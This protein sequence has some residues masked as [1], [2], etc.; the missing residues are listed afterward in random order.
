MNAH[1]HV[2]YDDD[3]TEREIGVVVGW[4]DPAEQTGSDDEVAPLPEQAHIPIEK[5]WHRWRLYRDPYG[6]WA[7]RQPAQLERPLF[8]GGNYGFTHHDR[9]TALSELQ[10][11][12]LIAK[13]HE[14]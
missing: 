13:S 8:R 2:E 5:R 1:I 4:V 7:A 10:L 12:V 9:E 14:D 11:A 3:H 6:R